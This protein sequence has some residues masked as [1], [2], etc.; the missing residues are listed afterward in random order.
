MADRAGSEEQPGVPKEVFELD[1]DERWQ[2]RLDEARARREVAL[3][4]K[5]AGKPQ[6]PRPKP[7]EVDGMSIEDM[8]EID[9]I[10]QERGDDKFDFADRLETIRTPKTDA[11]ESGPPT[12][13]PEP[14][15]KPTR[16]APKPAPVVEKAEAPSPPPPPP[17]APPLRR[18]IPQAPA[19][20]ARTRPQP[21]LVLPDAPDVSELAARYA[22]TLDTAEVV[23]SRRL[24][25]PVSVPE[26]KRHT[27]ELVALPPMAGAPH[28]APVLEPE[29]AIDRRR[30]IRP[31]GMALVL[32]VFASLPLTTEAPPLETGPPMPVV[33]TL[34][35]QPALGVTWSLNAFP[36]R[37]STSQWRPAPK[38]RQLAAPPAVDAV[39]VAVSS[40][41]DAL[42][43]PSSIRLDE[44]DWQTVLPL[45]P[46]PR[47][48]PALPN[49]GP[50][51]AP[52]A[53]EAAP[54][55]PVE[56]APDSSVAAP[57]RPDGPRDETVPLAPADPPAARPEAAAPA[58][59]VVE[60]DRL[61]VT[62]L[63]PTRTDRAL[64]EAIAGGIQSDGHELVRLRNVDFSISERNV[65]YFH[66]V[67]Q[68]AA[69]QLAERY[70]AELRDFTWF[71][72]SPVVGTAELWLAGTAP[73][74]NTS[75]R[76]QPGNGDRSEFLG[77]VFYRLG[78]GTELPENL[79]GANVLRNVIPG[80]NRN[81][82][83]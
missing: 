76:T 9:P 36:F 66:A 45:A 25:E 61:R 12:E 2:A 56:A 46:T 70:D 80:A 26:P 68:R 38:P 34:R 42:V 10:I 82:G 40:Q 5:A 20:E 83:N 44:P 4:E 17:S 28:D 53:V 57:P 23:T 37:T 72:P 79:P 1:K 30:V 16:R 67:D 59:T 6:K 73:G 41:V 21:S 3:R 71:R 14:V 8:P 43:A 24:S 51:T 32:L 11:V 35:V 7:W 19:P 31:L 75:G 22:A 27:A 74:G 15:F 54:V 77:N 48:V 52:A 49:L 33:D 47:D 55:E 13:V 50:D 64:A 78:L 69:A 62:V 65:R 63:A 81:G 58:E 18:T 60:A 39:D 29:A